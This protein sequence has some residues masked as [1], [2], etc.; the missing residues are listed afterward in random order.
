MDYLNLFGLISN[1][2]GAL[3]LAFSIK[4][5]DPLKNL[6]AGI[7]I[8]NQ[9]LTITSIKKIPFLIGIILLI[10]GFA[11]QLIALFYFEH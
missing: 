8:V 5:V 1:L 10:I 11:F 4:V 3:F 9:S 6:G 2:I 7:R